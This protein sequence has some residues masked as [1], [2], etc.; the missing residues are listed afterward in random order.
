LHHEKI[1]TLSPVDLHTNAREKRALCTKK[2]V[3]KQL[4]KSSAQLAYDKEVKPIIGTDGGFN[5]PIKE[6]S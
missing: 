3:Q 2:E 5:I 4:P 1:V 6:K